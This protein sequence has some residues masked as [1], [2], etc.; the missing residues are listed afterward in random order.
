MSNNKWQSWKDK[1]NVTPLDLLNPN[2]KLQNQEDSNER[3][4]ICKACPE[5]I[6]L[7]TQCKKCGCFMSAKTKLA[8]ASCPIGK[9]GPLT[10]EE[11]VPEDLT[12]TIFINIPSYKDPEIWQTVED[13]IKQAKYPERIFFGI[14]LQTDSIKKDLKKSKE[15]KNVTADV[16]KPGSIIGCQPARKNSHKFYNGEDFYLNMDSHMRAKPNWDVEIIREYKLEIK[17]SSTPTVFTGYAVPYD[18]DEN[19]LDVVDYLAVSSPTFFMS[20]S[21]MAHFIN[22]GVPQ[23]TP[24][25]SNPGVN[26]ASPYVSGHFFFTERLVIEE[27]PFMNEVTFTEEEPIMALRFFTAG[28][29]IVTPHKP[30]IYHRYGRTGRPLL[31]DDFPD[32][33]FPKNAESLNFFNNLI[34]SKRIDKNNGLLGKRTLEDYEKYSGIN[35]SDRSLH[36]GVVDGLPSGSF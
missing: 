2:A 24:R 33:F 34:K 19:G 25:Y 15:F 36:H 12:S 27:V 3:Y 5:F 6:K 7:T 8:Q 28:F 18:V 26:V 4:E 16:I 21:N 10:A 22:H 1:Y 17:K 11:L 29:N 9:W 20:E 35:F 31:W 32:L 30:F 14:T 23:F 13:F